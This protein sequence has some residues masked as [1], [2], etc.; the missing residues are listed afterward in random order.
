MHTSRRIAEMTR[1]RRQLSATDFDGSRLRQVWSNG[2][3]A[4]H[5]RSLRARIQPS[6]QRAR[7]CALLATAACAIRSARS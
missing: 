6:R 3:L 2:R 4:F 1:R 5:L 7:V